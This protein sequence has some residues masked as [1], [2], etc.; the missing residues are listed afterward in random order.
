[1][2]SVALTDRFAADRLS[3]TV[4]SGP[5]IQPQEYWTFFEELTSGPNSYFQPEGSFFETALK[6]VV[7]FSDIITSI[8]SGEMDDGALEFGHKNGTMGDTPWNVY[9][10]AFGD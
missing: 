6:L 8:T 7:A 4:N 5:L 3:S 10:T 2:A 1:M 9:Q